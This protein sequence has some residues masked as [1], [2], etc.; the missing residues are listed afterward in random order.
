L[1]AECST[2]GSDDSPFPKLP[3][4]NPGHGSYEVLE[5]GDGAV[6]STVAHAG[7]RGLATTCAGLTHALGFAPESLIPGL[8]ECL[9]GGRI[10]EGAIHAAPIPDVELLPAR[11]ELADLQA[12]LTARE[13][14]FAVR[15]LLAKVDRYEWIVLDGPPELGYLSL[16]AL[17]PATGVLVP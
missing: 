4:G 5:I 16:N 8:V 3:A 2:P 9:K 12:R 11:I 1:P 15:Q 7:I 14:L 17:A 13:N 6:N 10:V